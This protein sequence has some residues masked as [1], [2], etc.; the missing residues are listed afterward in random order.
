MNE[1]APQKLHHISEQII[2][3]KKS[4][5]KSYLSIGALLSQV[6]R[7]GLWEYADYT[8]FDA[9]LADPDI[10]MS[11]STASRMI[12][13]YEIF[14][15]HYGI[16]IEEMQTIDFSKVSELLPAVKNK[17]L[18]APEIKQLLDETRGMTVRDIR[19]HRKEIEG[20]DTD[21]CA[22]VWIEK[23]QWRCSKCNEVTYQDPF[24]TKQ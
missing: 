19:I 14:V 24:A 2:E 11:Y 17:Q 8:S 1:L 12:N 18:L 5:T 7:E 6:K 15:E 4:L 9:Y 22:H 16:S 20:I 3:A 23:K 10:C 21:N 13:V